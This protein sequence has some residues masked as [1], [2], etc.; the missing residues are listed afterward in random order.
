MGLAAPARTFRGRGRIALAAVLVGLIWGIGALLPIGAQQSSPP[1]LVDQVAV[2]AF[3]AMLAAFALVA[4]LILGIAQRTRWIAVPAA[5]LAI[6]GIVAALGNYGEDGLR[7]VGAEYLYG[8][9]FFTLLIG[10]IVTVVVLLVRREFALATLVALS[11]AGFVLAA[12]HGPNLVPIIWFG[13]AAGILTGA[14]P[15]AKEA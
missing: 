2:P 15:I 1:T 3:S 14:L 9:G 13:I 11:V 8:L 5:V 12:V 10:L 4:W 7:I 6:G